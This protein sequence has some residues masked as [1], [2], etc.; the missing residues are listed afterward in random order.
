MYSLKSL[1]KILKSSK[2]TKVCLVTSK[3][4]VKPLSWAIKEIGVPKS[5]IIFLP[6][7]EKAKEWN[8]LQKL[9]QKFSQLNLDR[10]SIVIVLGGGTVGDITGFAA[11]IYLR[12]IRYI[13]IPTTLVAQ[14]DSAH[15]GKTGVN[16]LKYKNQV[17]SYHLPIA[18][19][20]DTRFLNSL[21][22]EQIVDGLGEI[23]KAGFIKDP[24][25]I[26]L[27]E[28]HTLGN[29]IGSSDMKKIIHR[30]IAV[31]KYYTSLDFNDKG[32]R[33]LLNV[34]HTLGHAVELKYKISHGRAV[35]VGML[36]EAE[37]L[38]LLK[39]T[40]ASIKDDISNLLSK[41][42]IR[43]D[44]DM[45]ADWKTVM[46]DKK[47]LGKVIDFPTIESIGKARI[48]KISLKTLRR[49]LE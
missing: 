32:V 8:I 13:Q 3:K 19:I 26:F 42:G 38:G 9:L 17:G 23:I 29:L 27:L 37:L 45:K 22:Q 21:S 2:P 28:R 49:A 33:Q 20:I 39:I 6:D 5:Q 31:K 47:I 1:P 35:I 36:L 15:G 40:R 44:L 14:V 43:V 41:L 48:V 25:I 4:L 10:N 30:S 12:G 7:G 24:A 34:G 11:S 46:H 18:T 16:F